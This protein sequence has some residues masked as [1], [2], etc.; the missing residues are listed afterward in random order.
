MM[1]IKVR[2][3]QKEI[4]VSSIKKKSLIYDQGGRIKKV[5]WPLIKGQIKSE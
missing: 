1:T 4:L 3:S 5:K 2:K